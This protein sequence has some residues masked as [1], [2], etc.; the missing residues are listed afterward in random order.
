MKVVYIAGP[1]TAENDWERKM[2]ILRAQFVNAE[3]WKRGFW[4]LC[5]HMNTEFFSGICPEQVF[6]DGGLVFLRRS[7]C[8]ILVEGWENSKGTLAEIAEAERVGIPIYHTLEEFD[9]GELQHEMVKG[10]I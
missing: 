7:D 1:Y 6:V 2:N 4:G 3:I 9:K 10:S 8:V 5:P